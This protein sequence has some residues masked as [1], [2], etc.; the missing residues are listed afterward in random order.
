MKASLRVVVGAERR[1][2]WVGRWSGGRVRRDASG[3]VSFVIE[4]MR[5]KT[6]H[7]H[8]LFVG[9]EE[10][11]LAELALFERAPAHYVPPHKMPTRTPTGAVVLDE[12][13]LGEFLAAQTEAGASLEHR[14]DLRHSLK[15]WGVA[16]RRRDLRTVTLAELKAALK[17]MT[18]RKHRII[19]LKSFTGWLR[20]ED[21]LR[22]AED[23]TA[24]L[25]VPPSRAQQ[26]AG[27]KH[28]SLEHV[29]AVYRHIN[30]QCVRDVVRLRV[31]TGIHQNEMD[32]MA[33]GQCELREL[34]LRCGIW[35]TVRFIH[36][37]RRRHVLSLD[38]AA[39]DA[40]R[41]LVARKRAPTDRTIIDALDRAAARAKRPRIL[42]GSLRHTFVTASRAV[43]VEVKPSKAGISLETIRQIVGHITTDTT[44]TYYDGTEVPPMS[45]LPL[46]LDHRDDPPSSG[47][48]PMRA[49]SPRTRRR[50]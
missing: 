14:S 15:K 11:A 12:T 26:L 3:V 37:S 1:W 38:R 10:E 21:R 17:T 46:R 40:A 23:P 28:Y 41:R 19:A 42:P 39:F 48:R 44:S 2:Q 13:T 24:D 4:K 34:R 6:R 31:G 27:A 22:K 25:R 50:G 36:K 49:S 16:L 33:L 32:R 45:R 20:V 30:S 47:T 7:T 5:E 9:S 43:G 35:G 29:A 18:A 8:V